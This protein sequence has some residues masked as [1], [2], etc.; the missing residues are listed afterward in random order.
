MYNYEGTLA[1]WRTKAYGKWQKW[2]P[3]GGAMTAMKNITSQSEWTQ[4]TNVNSVTNGVYYI[5]VT[6]GLESLNIVSVTLTNSSNV[7]M[8]RG[9]EIIDANKIKVWCEENPLGKIIINAIP[10]KK[11]SDV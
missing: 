5:T 1:Y 8:Q 4:D 10:Q 7:S 3:L 11:E 2:Q 6:H 9:Y